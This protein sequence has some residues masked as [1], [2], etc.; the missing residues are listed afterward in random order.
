LWENEEELCGIIRRLLEDDGYRQKIGDAG[1]A[2]VCRKHTY[3]HRADVIL[4]RL[5]KATS[6]VSKPGCYF[7]FDRPDVRGLIPETAT[8]ILDIGCG[9]GKLGAA[10]RSSRS[11]H[12][13]G[14]EASFS[15]AASAR[16]VLDSVI[17]QKI[18]DVPDDQFPP[19]SFDCIVLAD[20]LEHL[21]DPAS[22]L[23]K[24]RLW[25]AAA[26]TLVVSVPNSRNHEIVDALVHGNWTYESAGLLDD[27]HVRCFTRR[28]MEKLFF[29]TGFLPPELKFVAGSGF[30]SFRK[31]SYSGTL[32]LRDL[33]VNGL[34]RPEA[35]EFFAYQLLLRT[36]KSP[37]RSFGLT[38]IIVVT[39][40]ELAYTRMCVESLISRTDEAVE[41][42]FVDNGSTDGTAAYLQGIPS[43]KV[44]Q[45]DSNRGFAP[46]VNQGLRIAQGDQILLLNNDCIVTTGWLSSLLEGLYESPDVGMIGPVSNC[47]SG[48]QQVEHGY[49]V[50]SSLDGFAWERRK[51]PEYIAATR[52]VGFCLLFRRS[53]LSKVGNLDERFETGCYEDDDFC[54]RAIAAGFKLRIAN[55]V[56]VHHFG[57]ATF[58]GSGISLT[59]AMQE[60]AARFHEKWEGEASGPAISDYISTSSSGVSLCMIVRDNES[61]IESCL[62]SIRPWV[63]E[64]I[65]VDTGSADGT[66]DICKRLGAR[67]FSFPWCDDFS[68]ARN[69]SLRHATREWIFWMDSDDLIDAVQGDRLR[70]LVDSEHKPSSLGYVMQVHCPSAEAGVM[71]VVDHVKLIRNRPE[72]RFEHRIHEQIL[73][74][75]R[76]VGGDVDFTDIFVVHHG[77]RQSPSQRERKLQRD[78]RILR[79]D[80]EEQ[81]DHPFIL[82][83]LG[84]T[85]DDAGMYPQAV[86]YLKRCLKVSGPDESH[87]RKA[88][89]ILV[90]SLRLSGA[91]TEAIRQV[92]GA[93]EIY[94]D[95]A[96]LRFRH[97]V[98]LQQSDQC[99]A[100]VQEFRL[101]LEQPSVRRFQ[102]IDNSITGYKLHH[103]LALALDRLGRNQEASE[104][105][106]NAL[107]HSPASATAQFEVA[108]HA[109]QTGNAVRLREVAS[110]ADSDPCH[111]A[112]IS[113]MVCFCEGDP[114]EAESVLRQAW[115][116][117]HKDVCLD[118]LAR[119]MLESG[120]PE[121]A[122]EPLRELA[123]LRPDC[124]A[125]FFN[126]AQALFYS[127]HRGDARQALLRS[128][129][130]RPDHQPA[131]RLLRSVS[132]TDL[133]RESQRSPHGPEPT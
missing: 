41:L 31:Q 114:D 70:K 8:R 37:Q 81:P 112:C 9:S 120:R 52:L 29:R 43:A 79:L 19:E 115:I 90:N 47:V 14:I 128:L 102:S 56:F 48:P 117:S 77:S 97:G 39:F 133:P 30:E 104:Q 67:V 98:L 16:R 44:V 6:R 18:C 27:D 131:L 11:S 109:L 108:R 10:L 94:P 103:N 42:I 113:A 82:F 36:R 4:D 130:L 95:D 50:L 84:M 64:M 38:S 26:G 24:C 3:G 116:E 92:Q 110:F 129:T 5:N 124:G 25:L 32:Q 61:I 33:T 71:T 123:D 83:N 87:V 76:R 85:C 101:L 49:T 91:I 28:E 22:A 66:A 59:R 35:E 20:V 127:G 12:V 74:S 126:L 51:T 99:E 88:W 80:L 75:I 57:S 17:C 105:W 21:R 125:T 78:F 15:A 107:S 122:V 73:P 72:L 132:V 62:L 55:H 68:A 7:E 118:E 58:R 65:I 60:N 119:L 100:A 111:K 106:E 63:D 53:V 54:R 46:A 45:N 86:D 69:E 96:E 89:S 40:N 1:R 93:L 23:R 13:T 121:R 34:S 2:A